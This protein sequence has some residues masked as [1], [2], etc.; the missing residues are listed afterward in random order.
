MASYD[1]PSKEALTNAIHT[2]YLLLDQEFEDID[3]NKKDVLIPEVDKTP[4]QIIAY[5]LGWLDLVMGWEKAE[6]SG[7]EVHMPAPGYKW[8]QLGALYSSFYAAYASYSLNE[9]RM[10][11]QQ[12]EQQWLCWVDTLSEEE[13]FT[14][15][16]RKWT[17][18]KTNWPM[19]RWIHINSAAPFKTFRAKLR[20]W[21]KYEH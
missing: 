17:G 4:A 14:Q 18:E 11:L 9:L 7:Q 8:N 16:A 3:N 20:R 5:Q 13:L 15:G 6:R 1:Y 19:S 12:A 2:A 10:L 21:K